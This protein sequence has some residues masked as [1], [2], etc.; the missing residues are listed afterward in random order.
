MP[1]DLTSVQ[2]YVLLTLMIRTGPQPLTLF[3]SLKLDARKKLVDKGL[4]V[5]TEKPITLELTQAGHDRAEKEFGA[6][7]PAR[8]GTAGVVVRSLLE[9]VQRLMAHTGTDAQNVFRL[10]FDATA[11]AVAREDAGGTAERV[12]T[13]DLETRIRKAYATLAP[14]S[15]D[16]IML[17]ELRAEL[18]GAT[19]QDVDAALLRLQLAP[20]VHLVPESNQKVLT[21]RQRAAAIDIGNQPKHLIAISA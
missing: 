10:R 18:P 21:D 14:Q 1:D 20:D 12:E 15:G 2:R 8:S 13:T 6:E 4:I 3:K 5:T 11:T 17:D 19:R 9:Y 16:Y 7:P